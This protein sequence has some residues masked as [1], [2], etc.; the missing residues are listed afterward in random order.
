MLEGAGDTIE[1]AVE[2]A[3]PPDAL[4]CNW[5][6]HAVTMLCDGTI[7]CGLDD[8]FKARNHGSVNTAT[9]R[10]V[11]AG[12]PI[13]RRRAELKAGT[14]CKSCSMYKRVADC[15]PSELAPRGPYP[16]RLI[17][18]SSIKCNIRCNNETCNIAN[19]KD[20]VLRDRSFVDWDAFCR[21]ID[22]VGPHIEELY[23]YNYGEPFIHPRAL[24]MLAYAKKV[25]PRVHVS[26]S[27]NGILL[28]RNNDAE[29]LVSEGLVDRITFTIG[30]VDQQSY[31]KYHKSGSFEKAIGG[32]RRVLEERRRIGASKPDVQW[33]YL[34]FRWNDSDEQL[35]EAHRLREELAP[36]QFH[37]MLTTSP[38]EGRSLRRAPSAT[39]FEAI[40]PW[41]ALQ[42]GFTE[43]PFA[44][45]GLFGP[46]TCR[47]NGRFS[48]TG[49]H[50]RLVA[51]PRDGKIVVR[52]ARGGTAAGALPDV[53]IRLPWGSLLAG[54]GGEIW[55]ENT[56][57][58]PASYRGDEIPVELEVAKLF[59][60]MRHGAGWGDNRT[61]GVMLSLTDIAPAPNPFRVMAPPAQN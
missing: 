44:E 10:D 31:S 51:T 52:L 55:V 18:E 59:T 32:M 33:R 25:N 42:E 29:R 58:I 27:T 16:R 1:S 61:L 28:T 36:D 53:T 4:H 39:G 56:F 30:G 38:I 60:P 7:T 8:P 43:N 5:L 23:F 37:F 54:V 35:A 41:L 20:I 3:P 6:S 40:R 22:E 47:V 49:A 46:E 17:V 15:H 11:F 14:P 34:L 12:E 2:T 9:V 19:D 26:T 57:A 48:W 45:A 24:D 50:A 21:V 13:A